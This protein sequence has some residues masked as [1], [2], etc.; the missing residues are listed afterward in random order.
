MVKNFVLPSVFSANF[1]D[2]KIS[3]LGFQL[4][5]LEKVR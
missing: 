3:N 1:K 2:L 4:Q 5:K